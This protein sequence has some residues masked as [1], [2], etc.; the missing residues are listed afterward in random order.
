VFFFISSS[1]VALISRLLCQ[2]RWIP[3]CMRGIHG[4]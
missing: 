1:V 4:N 2:C 3:V